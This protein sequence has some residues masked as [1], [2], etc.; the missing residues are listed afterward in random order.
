MKDFNRQHMDSSSGS[1]WNAKTAL[2][3]LQESVVS[4]L[5]AA[6]ILTAAAVFACVGVL[7]AATVFVSEAALRPAHQPA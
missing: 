4:A 6:V 2:H 3:I 7:V 1:L 5:M